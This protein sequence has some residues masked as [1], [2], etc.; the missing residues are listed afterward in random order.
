[1]YI[2]IYIY[3]YVHRRGPPGPPT[4]FSTRARRGGSGPGSCGRPLVGAALEQDRGA[5]FWTL[6]MY[7]HIYIYTYIYIYVY[8]Y[9]Y[10]CILY[11]ILTYIYIYI[12]IHTHLIYSCLFIWCMLL[13]PGAPPLLWRDAVRC[14][15]AAAVF[16]LTIT[17]FQ[18]ESG[19]FLD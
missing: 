5:A 18:I 19:R 12:Y 6:H 17:E 4:C 10:T 1:M 2:Y 3:I 16:L 8:E 14:E 11:H 7:T 13:D 9:M 15:G